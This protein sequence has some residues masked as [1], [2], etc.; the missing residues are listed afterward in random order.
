MG[1]KK[2]RGVM[3]VK[4]GMELLSWCSSVNSQS[5]VVEEI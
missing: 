1:A 3:G 5:L 2:E 4:G